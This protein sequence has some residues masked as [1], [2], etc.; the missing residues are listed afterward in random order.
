LESTG[1]FSGATGTGRFDGNVD[2]SA[3]GAVMVTLIGEIS[4]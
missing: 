2:F 4:Y 1:R 3:G